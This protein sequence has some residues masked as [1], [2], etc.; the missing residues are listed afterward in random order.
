MFDAK[1][2]AIIIFIISYVGIIFT[3]LPWVNIDR[4]SAAFFGAVAMIVSGIVSFNEAMLA[5]DFHTISLLIGMMIIITVLSADGAFNFLM[6]KII[7]FVPDNKKFLWFVIFFTGISSAFMVND[8]VVLMVTPL[9]I[10]ICQSSSINPVPYLIAEIFSTNAGSVMTITGNPQNMLIGM[11]SNISY[12]SFM[13]Y[14]LPISLIS[15]ILI[16]YFITLFYKEEFKENKVI[17]KNFNS[18]YRLKTLRLAFFIFGIVLFGF[19][20]GHLIK[21]PIS[22]IALSGASIMLLFGHSKPRRV[23]DKVDWILILFFCS[24]FILIKGLEKTGTFTTIL[25]N[26]KLSKSISGVYLIH[27]ISLIGSQIISNVPLTMFMV[28]ILHNAPDALWLSLASS[29]TL[30][31][32]A[33]IIGAIANIIVLESAK[34]LGINITF[35]EFLKIGLPFTIISLLVSLI[36]FQLYLIFGIL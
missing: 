18:T 14:L 36:I 33:T 3:R 22:L 30:G 20:T 35:L 8:A 16:Y 27:L 9:I 17:V 1:T 19:F 11:K 26:I 15:M 23:I 7:K 5:I 13:L 4:P 12:L 34:R 24:L 21:I 29:S 10:A 28:P 32:N 2:L 25:E 31:G 6:E